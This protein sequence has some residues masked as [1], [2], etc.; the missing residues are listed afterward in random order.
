[1]RVD[2]ILFA[3]LYFLSPSFSTVVSSI[4]GE[5]LLVCVS[6]MVEA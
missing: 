2:C 6:D 3:Y 4:M 1:M 5:T